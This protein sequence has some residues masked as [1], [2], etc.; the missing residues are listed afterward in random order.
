[1]EQWSKI[2]ETIKKKL[3]HQT[4]EPSP[5]LWS[6][7][8]IGLEQQQMVNK[9]NGVSWF[10]IAASVVLFLGVTVFFLFSTSK[11]GISEEPIDKDFPV[12]NIDKQ[13]IKQE[14]SRDM[15]RVKPLTTVAVVS[16]TS[17]PSKDFKGAD[18]KPQ[19]A[20]SEAPKTSVFS[21]TYVVNDEFD[22]DSITI[23]ALEP[24]HIKSF[25]V[26]PNS[27]LMEVE[28]ELKVEYRETVFDQLKRNFKSA[29]SNFANRNY[30]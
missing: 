26:D 11:V 27:L 30:K 18:L 9:K 3:D 21:E 14:E 7:I 12:V 15:D 1:M 24:T 25:K 16:T 4:L 13:S 8:E 23:L 19:Q 5:D 6:K 2:E 28:S 29:K 20:Q 10:L 17:V 22:L